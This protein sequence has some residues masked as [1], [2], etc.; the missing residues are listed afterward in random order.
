[1]E[2]LRNYRFITNGA[3]PVTGVDDSDML[4]ETT[5]AMM[6]MGM[7]PEEQA[8][9]FRIVA[10]VLLMGNMVFKTERNT[11]QAV[12]PDNTSKYALHLLLA[13]LLASDFHSVYEVT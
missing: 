9:V 12:L 8:S 5:E 7:A 2:D 11:D 10:G 4:R 13:L 3:L 1:M 6:I